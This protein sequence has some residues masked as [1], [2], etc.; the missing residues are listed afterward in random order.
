MF[1]IAT[2]KQHDI[3]L[4]HW[5][6]QL[7]LQKISCVIQTP[8][9]LSCRPANCFSSIRLF[10]LMAEIPTSELGISTSV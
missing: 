7:H 9:E 3:K 10:T 6:F 5:P 1:C 8:A 2:D 4:F